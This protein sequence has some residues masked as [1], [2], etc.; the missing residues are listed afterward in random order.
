MVVEELH[1]VLCKENIEKMIMIIL[2]LAI[3]AIGSANGQA[4]IRKNQEWSD[5]GSACPKRCEQKE[6]VAC[7]AVCRPGCVCK[8]GFCLR[9][10][11][12]CVA[13]VNCG[14]LAK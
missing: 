1:N 9:T 4:V 7:P 10:S 11:G 6:P 8:K 13:D 3:L 5:C 2:L 14:T 12:D